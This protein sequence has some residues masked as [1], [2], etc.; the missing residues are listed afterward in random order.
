[1]RRV[2]QSLA[3]TFLV[4]IL[5]PACTLEQ[6]ETPVA[7]SDTAA[8]QS[9]SA[10][11]QPAQVQPA[12]NQPA[13]GSG[14]TASSP[15]QD[16]SGGP[17]WERL[18]QQAKAVFE[19]EEDASKAFHLAKQALEIAASK[20]G[21]EHPC[22]ATTLIEMGKYY[23]Y[24]GKPEDALTCLRE[25]VS[26]REKSL[27]KDHVDTGL[28]LFYLGQRLSDYSRDQEAE[29]LLKRSL[30]ILDQ[31]L[32]PNHPDLGQ[33]HYE[34]GMLYFIEKEIHF[35][36]GEPHV[37]QA[38]AIREQA[39]GPNSREARYAHW[40]LGYVLHKH[41]K[42]AQAEPHL[43]KFIALGEQSGEDEKTLLDH[44]WDLAL[45][46]LKQGKEPT[47]DPSVDQVLETAVRTKHFMSI[48]FIGNLADHYKETGQ[49]RKYFALLIKH[50]DLISLYQ[51]KKK[52]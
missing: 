4:A 22:V 52:P 47:E 39:F 30:T 25:A 20:H 32:P 14:T 1:M 26:I 8:G 37:A 33:A 34:Y 7:Q 5:F 31:K 49:L 10:Q 12:Q 41:G 2:L 19:D 9:Q 50:K 11:V 21:N 3:A 40:A 13:Q 16:V 24:A 15:P 42:Y 43:K 46:Y 35:T 29:P 38:L 27:G 28:A 44:R 17:E 36:E 18:M 45:N 48:V 6:E 23:D 51:K